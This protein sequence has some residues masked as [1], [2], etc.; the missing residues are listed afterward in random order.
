MT[1]QI[2]YGFCWLRF[3]LEDAELGVDKPKTIDFCQRSFWGLRTGAPWRDL[4]PEYGDWKNTHRRFCRWRD[5][6][7]WEHVLANP[8]DMP[9]FEW[10]MIDSTY[11]KVHAHAAGA[12]EVIRT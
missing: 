9:N 12:K 7:T 10:L 2:M 4:P 8:M 1:F 5:K 6:G 3:Y 11:C